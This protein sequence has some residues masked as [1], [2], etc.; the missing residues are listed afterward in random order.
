MKTNEGERREWQTNQQVGG[1]GVDEEL[2]AFY[3]LVETD[4]V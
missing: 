3:C 1:G 4:G 2:A